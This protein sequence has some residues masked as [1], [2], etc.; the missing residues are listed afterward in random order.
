MM[1][2]ETIV[3]NYVINPQSQTFS[4]AAVKGNWSGG[5]TVYTTPQQYGNLNITADESGNINGIIYNNGAQSPLSGTI[6]NSGKTNLSYKY[7]DDPISGTIN[8]TLKIL[9]NGKAIL[10]FD[11]SIGENLFKGQATIFKSYNWKQICTNLYNNYSNNLQSSPSETISYKNKLWN[12]TIE[13]NGQF[14]IYNSI[15]GIKWQRVNQISCAQTNDTMKTSFSFFTFNNRMWIITF[16]SIYSSNDGTTWIQHTSNA[17]FGE[18]YGFACCE[19]NGKLWLTGG[20]ILGNEYLDQRIY[21]RDSW[22]SS[23]GIKWIKAAEKAEYNKIFSHY[24]V[25]FQNKL[26]IVGTS[27][28]A[29][30]NGTELEK[31][32]WS[33][34]DGIKWNK[35]QSN[36]NF[37]A[38]IVTGC[39]VYNGKIHILMKENPASGNINSQAARHYVSADG[40]NWSLAPANSIP[41]NFENIL[42]FN[43]S[44]YCVDRWPNSFMPQISVYKFE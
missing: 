12:A 28:A 27:S 19:F 41:G 30:Q 16:G 11:N 37:N 44:L 31:S 42:E 2:S 15:N 22:Y 29:N 23:D 5:F 25:N 35:V 36:I 26:W 10:N 14:A 21:Q 17:E 20:V 9:E 7:T 8:G 24:M 13:S 1:N 40:Y 38:I 4:L 18:R 6:D 43:N 32:I 33:S 34:S 39:T 3:E